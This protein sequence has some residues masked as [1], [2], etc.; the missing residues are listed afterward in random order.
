MSR[1]RVLQTIS[2]GAASV[3]GAYAYK[4]F[5]FRRS[6]SRTL[7]LPNPPQPGTGEFARL[8]ET[9]TQAPLREGNLVKVLRNGREI[10]PALLEAIKTAQETINFS[11][12]IWWTG[13]AS[14]DISQALAQRARDGLQVRVLIDAWGSAKL[15]REV[16]DGL[17]QA[18]AK[19]AWFRPPRWYDL[20]RVN[21]RMHRRILAVDGRLGFAGGVGIAEEWEGDSDRPRLWRETHL[22]IEGP[23]VR[24][25]LGAFVENWAEAVGEVLAGRHLPDLSPVEGGVPVLVTRSS[26]TGGSTAVEELLLAVVL[27][28]RHRLWIT[29][30]Y[31]APSSGYVDELCAAAQRGVDVRILVNG[32]PIDKEVVRK[33][34]QHSYGRLLESGVRIFEYERA[35]LHAKV[36]VVDDGWAN[37]GSSNFDNRSMALEDEI[38]ISIHD[39]KIAAELAEHFLDDLSDSNEI[40]LNAWRHRPLR[41]RAGEAASELVRHS[42]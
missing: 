33:S 14:Q 17:R 32:Q 18:G 8:L 29:T 12:Y 42:L 38:N 21:N 5:Q 25:L 39:S 11:T 16:V 4:G 13:Q 20:N 2:V 7:H 23:A 37:V 31:F 30:A 36:I 35:R 19:V 40:T 34:G 6:G 9:F 24:D 15:E 27:G 10:F 3:V 28:A 1:R 26:A 22:R 41:A